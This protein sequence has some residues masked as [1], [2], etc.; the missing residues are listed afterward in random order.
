VIAANGPRGVEVA[1]RL[2]L[3]H[4]CA[5][6]I[7]EGA[8]DSRYM[9]FGTVLDDDEGFDSDAVFERL[10]SA[11]AVVYHG[12]YAMAGAAV[13]ALPGGAEWR[14][15]MEKVPENLRHLY[16][17][18]DHLVGVTE[19]DRPHLSRDLA[20]TTFS[21]TRAQM[22]ER[23]KELGASGIG[24]LIFWPTGPDPERELRAM[25]EALKG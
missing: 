18:E 24:E 22:R 8:A 2:G 19:R 3:G 14:A 6:M 11:I 9:G 21:G 7:P 13:D 23:A 12:T 25:A 15:A 16:L 20:A 5:G 1:R 10:A 4:M 17:H